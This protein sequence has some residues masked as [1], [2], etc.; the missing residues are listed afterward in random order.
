[1]NP[2]RRKARDEPDEA[3]KHVLVIGGN[4]F[5]LALAEYLTESAQSVTFVSD[6]QPTGGADGVESIHREISNAKDVRSLAT[7]VTDVDFVVA[8]GSDT[9]ALLSGY[10]VRRELDPRVVV[11]SV[12]D[13]TNDT[14]FE[15]TGIDPIDMARLL[16]EEIHDRYE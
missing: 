5:G 15:G 11:A 14:A 7:E 9:Q 12:S 1:M 10:L 2:T 4:R 16:A 6:D 13:P 3:A 8:V